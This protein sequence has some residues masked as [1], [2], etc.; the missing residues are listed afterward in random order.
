MKYIILFLISFGIANAS[1]LEERIVCKVFATPWSAHADIY[2][3]GYITWG[4]WSRT[5]HRPADAKQCHKEFR[6]VKVASMGDNLYTVSGLYHPRPHH[7]YK[8]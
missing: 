7:L 2:S 5:T 3:D 6:T 4:T 1:H 8:Q